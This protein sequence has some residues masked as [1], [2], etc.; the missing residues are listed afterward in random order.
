MMTM[1]SGPYYAIPQWPSVHHTMGGLNITPKTEV[2]DI[3]GEVIPGLFAAGEITGGI[4]GTNRLG[5]NAV[6][7]CCANGYITAAFVTGTIAGQYAATGTLPDF[8][9]GK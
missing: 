9:K 2:R 7:D 5:S 1:E 3:Y 8:I 6:A 4:H